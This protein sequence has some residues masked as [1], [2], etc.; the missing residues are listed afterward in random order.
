MPKCLLFQLN[1]STHLNVHE[2]LL[3][4]NFSDFGEP[5]PVSSSAQDLRSFFVD[6]A[7][8]YESL[9]GLDCDPHKSSAAITVLQRSKCNS[10]IPLRPDK[11]TQSQILG[12]FVTIEINNFSWS[13]DFT[14][15]TSKAFRNANDVI[16]IYETSDEGISDA[17]VIIFDK[18]LLELKQYNIL[19]GLDA[20]DKVKRY[21]CRK[22][23]TVE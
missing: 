5:S 16:T 15:L 19:D 2:W 12:E 1:L 7:N 4:S 8:L 6:T 3:N 23:M 21:R 11:N 18:L 22:I 9:P 17:G 20:P 10:S 13:Q 14:E